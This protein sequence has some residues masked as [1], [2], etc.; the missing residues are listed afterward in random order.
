MPE[1]FLDCP[2]CGLR[3][4]HMRLLLDGGEAR[5][6]EDLMWY[7]TVVACPRCALVIAAGQSDA[8]DV[9]VIPE[10]AGGGVAHLPQDVERHFNDALR[11]GEYGLPDAAALLL[12]KTL[13][14]AAAHHGHTERQLVDRIKGLIADGL[15]TPQ[16]GEA[17]HHV[18][19]VGNVGAH[20]GAPELDAATVKRVILFTTAILRELFEIP[21]EL[22]AVR[23]RGAANE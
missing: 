16:F 12:R 14:A 5:D 3:D 20:A 22:A 9:V 15:I 21:S 19:E 18:R 2:H 10:R 8:D 17:L 4:A 13:E 11:A 23:P 1:F 6:S 7:W